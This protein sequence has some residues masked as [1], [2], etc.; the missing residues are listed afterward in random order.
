MEHVY[1]A[2]GA[3]AGAASDETVVLPTP[4]T[5]RRPMDSPTIRNRDGSDCSL[6]GDGLSSQMDGPE[7]R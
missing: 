4:P 1:L 2:A 5:I 7:F 6:H 3:A